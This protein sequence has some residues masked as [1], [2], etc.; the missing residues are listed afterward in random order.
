MNKNHAVIDLE[1]YNA[2]RDKAEKTD[3]IIEKLEARHKKEVGSILQELENCIK[4]TEDYSG[5]T[6]AVEIVV[7]GTI[8]GDMIRNALA[9]MP[10]KYSKEFKTSRIYGWDFVDKIANDAPELCVEKE[11]C[12]VF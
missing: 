10:D 9:K 2:L 12:E 3:A 6:A 1:E 8:I 5:H 11:T 4:V 7:E